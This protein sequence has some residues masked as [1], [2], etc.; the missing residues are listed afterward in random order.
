MHS[1]FDAT[2]WWSTKSSSLIG[3]VTSNSAGTSTI[4]KKSLFKKERMYF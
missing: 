2:M 1:T 4:I 3:D